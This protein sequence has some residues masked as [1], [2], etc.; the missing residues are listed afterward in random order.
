[1]H[2]DYLVLHTSWYLACNIPC[3]HLFNEILLYSSLLL[4]LTEYVISSHTIKP[5]AVYS[6]LKASL[7]LYVYKFKIGKYFFSVSM[8]PAAYSAPI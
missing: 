8:L 1:M 2:K 4:S 7:P 3:V 6:I 5:N